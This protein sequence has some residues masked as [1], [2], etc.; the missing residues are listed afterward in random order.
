[1]LV[2][3]CRRGTSLVD[4]VIMLFIF[5]LAGIVFSASF[6]AAFRANKEAQEYKTATALAQRKM[7]QLRGLNYQSLTYGILYQNG[8]I[9]QNYTGQNYKFT[10]VD[11][12]ADKLPSGIGSIVVSDDFTDMKRVTITVSWAS[13]SSINRNI[14]LTTYFVDR[15]TRKVN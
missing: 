3:K 1:M 11:G 6:P 5:G 15:R 14:Q 9:D 2:R 13:V 4:V 7:E 10:S 12:V 8:Y